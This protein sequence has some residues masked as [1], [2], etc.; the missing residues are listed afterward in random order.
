MSSIH[1]DATIR[2]RKVT[3]NEDE[4]EMGHV[5]NTQNASL[6][7]G[8]SSHTTE[9]TNE[10]NFELSKVL[11]K[12]YTQIDQLKDRLQKD[13][14]RRCVQNEW[15]LIGT[16]LDKILFLTYCVIVIIST[17]AIFKY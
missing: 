11:K 14:Y 12:I 3:N 4:T 16:I 13:T 9:S 8:I 17:N 15:L 10:V 7:D 2:Y 5:D 6:L 1:P